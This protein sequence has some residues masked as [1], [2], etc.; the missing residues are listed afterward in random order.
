MKILRSK[1]LFALLLIISI[2]LPVYN[3][4]P[5]I[6]SNNVV[7]NSIT[8]YPQAVNRT[9][10][11]FSNITELSEDCYINREQPSLNEQPS[12]YIPNYN[13][14]YADMS[15][16]NITAL[17]YT[18]SIENDFSEFIISSLNGPMYIYQKFA[19][20]MDQYANNVSILIQ[21]YNDPF[22]FT[23]ENSWEVAIVNCLT[24]TNGTPNPN[25]TLGSLKKPHPITY[26][27]HWEV[28]DF[29]NSDDG[30]IYLNTSTTKM[31]IE[32]GIEK[33][34]FAFRIKIPPDDRFF[35]GGPKFL[36]FNPDDYNIGEG[37][38]FAISPDFSFDD[39]TV[40]NVKD[41]QNKSGNVLDGD[42]GS[43]RF[44][45]EDRFRMTGTQNITL[46]VEFNLEEL[47]N[48]EF[49]FWELFLK[50]KE[51]NWWI[52]HYK[53]IFSFDI[54]LM[55]NIS[56]IADILGSQLYIRNFKAGGERWVPLEY[57]IKQENETMIYYSIR[58]PIEKYH[59]LIYMNNQPGK[60][61]TL[62]FRLEFLS[63]DD[64]NLSI[65]QFKVEVGELEILDT[66]QRHDPLIQELHFPTN[67]AIINGSTSIFEPQTI[68][69][70]QY[71]DNKYYK[72]QALTN[73][74]TYFVSFNVLEDFDSSLW[75]VDYYDWI[76]S[77][78]NP[79][80]PQMDIRITSNVSRPDNL[81]L[82]ALALYKGNKTFDI[83]EPAQNNASWILIS[84]N[85][86][87]AYENET[88]FVLRFDAGFTWLFLNVLDE[89][90]NNEANLVLVYLTNNTGDYGF[91][92]SIN[93][94][95]INL[96]IQN[97]ISSD[98]SS[99]IGLGI[100]NNILTPSDI[101]LKNFGVSVNDTG[102]GMGTWKGDIDDA[103][104]SQGFF[105]FNITS[106]WHAIQFDVSGTYEIFK[107]IPI[108][109]FVED[110][111]S[112]YMIGTSVFSVRITETGGKALENRE[113]KFEILNPSGVP[114]SEIK[115]RSNEEGIAV[116]SIIFESTGEGF[117]IRARFVEAGFYTNGEIVSGSIR[118][119][120]GF[121]LFMDSF[122]M[123]LP[124]I[125]I[126]ALA[127]ASFFTVKSIKHAKSRKFWAGEAKILDDLVKISYIM[128]IHKYIGVSI[129]NKQ[130]SLEGIDSDL[131]SGFLQAISQFR[132]E[133][134]KDSAAAKGKEFEMDYGDFKIVIADGDYVRV[135]LIL[136]GTPSEKLKENQWLFTEHF[137]KRFGA[138][139]TDFTGDITP[140]RET[141][142][143]VEKHF[144]VTLV[145]PLQLGKHYGVIKLKGLEKTL[146]EVAEQIQKERKFFFISSLIN[147][148]LAGRKASRDE[149]ISAIID[150][151]RKGL[152]IPAK[153]E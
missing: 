33:Y 92:I 97:V 7:D 105:E 124:Y 114:I 75:D 111:A 98:I 84:R 38:T 5:N 66:I 31:T 54:Y 88:T 22:S 71:N 112:Q 64:I 87:F 145:Y 107:I 8:I 56:D 30:P 137:E 40:N 132:S 140:F 106:L 120:D 25:E 70:F 149:I 119:V 128:I 48:S 52:D 2:S 43:F 35:G 39:Y 151:K 11:V 10:K 86:Q 142:D 131:I 27:T 29:Q 80:V 77:Y 32:N 150:L 65:N 117:S 53:Y 3:A 95:S 103:V 136:D 93:E 79:L 28:F 81:P 129:Y 130:I 100:N 91:N 63:S 147:Y 23:D 141:D 76:A 121:I 148:V 41:Y 101:R 83:L 110:P 67:V 47:K 36:Y 17:N 51:I 9:G 146:T 59:M 61:N 62:Q 122:L 135:A 72:A 68:E 133:I 113:I 109:E 4:F 19:V 82:A 74:L 1:P 20:E 153:V 45:D 99:S 89:S 60:N 37:E 73:N 16:E 134:K 104:F 90:K 49:T 108:L 44:I 69:A 42:L 85:T 143:L 21:D 14:S 127:I 115:S 15:F 125:I 18:R 138:L 118:V 26:A 13:I 46:D 6:I 126:A 94:F 50:P 96:Y 78:P 116:A 144:N 24:D 55:L 152:I 139:L 12:I 102:I 57:D 58:N 34:W 123:Y